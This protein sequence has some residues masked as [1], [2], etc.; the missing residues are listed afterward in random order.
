MNHTFLLALGTW[1]DDSLM[2]NYG[3]GTGYIGDP[4]HVEC[5][6]GSGLESPRPTNGDRSYGATCREDIGGGVS[7]GDD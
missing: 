1:D 4:W 3:G 2:V 5:M 6:V 7:P